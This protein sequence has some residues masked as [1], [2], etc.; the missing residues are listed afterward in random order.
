MKKGL[1]ILGIGFLLVFLGAEADLSFLAYPGGIAMIAGCV[2]VGWNFDTLFKSSK[3]SGST[4]RPQ[5][6]KPQ[7]PKPEPSKPAPRP[8]PPKPAQ[9]PVKPAAKFCRHCGAQVEPG[10]IYCI[11]CGNKVS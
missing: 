9:E 7:P 2:L 6:P 1:I 11:E 8:E 5:P 3:K 4:P 10:D